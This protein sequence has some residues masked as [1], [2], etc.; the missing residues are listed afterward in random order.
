M[1]VLST[2]ILPRVFTFLDHVFLTVLFPPF[3]RP[4]HVISSLRIVLSV[5]PGLLKREQQKQKPTHQVSVTRKE[6]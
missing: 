1:F 3:A 5:V 4:A 6:I 2:T